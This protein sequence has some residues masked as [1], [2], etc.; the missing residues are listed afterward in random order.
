MNAL[1]EQTRYANGMMAPVRAPGVLIADDMVMI[2]TVLKVELQARGFGVWLAIDGDDALDLY[3]RHRDEIDVVLLDVQMPG[4][5]GPHTLAGLQRLDPDV[6]VCFMSG[7]TGAYSE[8]E[9]RDRGAA[10]VFSKPFRAWDVA[11]HLQQLLP[12]IDPAD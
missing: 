8:Q 6:V 1:A 2:L 7:D 9:L 3:R 10:W 4:L 12:S 5:D 11:D